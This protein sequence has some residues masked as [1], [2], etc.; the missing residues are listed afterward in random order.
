MMIKGEPPNCQLSNFGHEHSSNV[1]I[2]F[3]WLGDLFPW[4]LDDQFGLMESA[5][6]LPY[7]ND[8]H[9]FE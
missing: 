4:K 6:S 2:L 1:N 9:G 5:P 3:F 8:V 7:P